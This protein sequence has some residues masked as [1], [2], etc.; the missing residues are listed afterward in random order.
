MFILF[1][2]WACLFVLKII[3]ILHFRHSDI[4]SLLSILNTFSHLSNGFPSSSDND[5]AIPVTI[6][7]TTK[8]EKNMVTSNI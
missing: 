5:I 3:K 1:N 2:I 6:E 8:I 7:K 4:A